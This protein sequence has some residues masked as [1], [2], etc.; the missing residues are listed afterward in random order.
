M[1]GWGK[2]GGEREREVKR[3]E[4]GLGGEFVSRTDEDEW[5]LCCRW[6]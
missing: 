4:E 3:R 1:D 5:M 6:A 2:R